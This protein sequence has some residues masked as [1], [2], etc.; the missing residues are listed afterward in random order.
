V[1]H[2]PSPTFTLSGTAQP[3]ALHV[4]VVH[5]GTVLATANVGG[6]GGWS[7]QLTVTGRTTINVVGAGGATSPTYTV[8]PG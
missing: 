6:D 8:V 5:G 1:I 7:T 4:S 3:L 2:A